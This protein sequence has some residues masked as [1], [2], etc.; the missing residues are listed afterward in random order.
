[1]LKLNV[2]KGRAHVKIRNKV[3]GSVLQ[4]TVQATC[5]GIESRLELESEE[6]PEKIAELVRHAESGCFTFQALINPVQVTRTVLLNGKPLE[7]P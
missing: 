1:M 6:P 2:E 7:M 4:G 3:E 5:L